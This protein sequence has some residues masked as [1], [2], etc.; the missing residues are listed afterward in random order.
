MMDGDPEQGAAS[1]R[2][3]MGLYGNLSEP[4]IAKQIQGVR[5]CNLRPVYRRVPEPGPIVFARGI[6]IDLTVDEQAFSGNSPYL[7]GSVL[8]RLFSRLV[9][10]NT[11][12]EMTLSS[13]Q[14]GEIAHW[15][16]RMGKGR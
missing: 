11:F 15:Q 10:M 6:A 5:H 8:E 14:R 4:A 16:A 9:A 12:T 7:L 2:Q 1:L 13:Q 3:L